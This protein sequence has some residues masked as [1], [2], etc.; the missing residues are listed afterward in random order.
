MDTTLLR[1]ACHFNATVRVRGRDH[2]KRS[3]SNVM[4]SIHV[5]QRTR[6]QTAQIHA[7]ST[8]D[9][10][11]PGAFR[12]CAKRTSQMSASRAFRFS[13]LL[14]GRRMRV[15]DMHSK[16]I[17][18]PSGTACTRSQGRSRALPRFPRTSPIRAALL[19]HR[20]QTTKEDGRLPLTS[21]RPPTIWT[22]QEL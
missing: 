14:N 13:H 9:R 16:I 6:R 11:L 2:A 21:M 22:Q 20:Q 10:S 4:I 15:P 8:A 7:C 18:M 3:T 5:G 17:F 1:Y 12:R 19:T